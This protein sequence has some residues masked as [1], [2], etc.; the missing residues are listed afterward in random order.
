MADIRN[1]PKLNLK[2]LSRYIADLILVGVGETDAVEN[3]NTRIAWHLFLFS[4][5]L[6]V[7][8]HGLIRL[9]IAPSFVGDTIFACNIR[10]F[11]SIIYMYLILTLSFIVVTHYKN[12]L[13]HGKNKRYI[14]ICF[15]FVCYIFLFARLY[16]SLFNYNP[17]LFRISNSFIFLSSEFGLKGKDDIISFFQFI[18]F[19]TDSLFNR[20]YDT[21]KSNSILIQVIT[22][23]EMIIGFL[24]ISFIVAVFVSIST[25]KNNE[26]GTN[27]NQ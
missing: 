17:E 11:E 13:I 9:F 14:T 27:Q 3:K 18:L 6:F 21:I 7:I 20:S 25:S 5:V 4:I 2:A 10:L 15:F 22:T 1:I 16:Y 12:I 24:L 23:C 26:N 19:S 8:W